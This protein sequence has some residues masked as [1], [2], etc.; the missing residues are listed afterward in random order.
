MG[1]KLIGHRGASSA[2]A[3][4]TIAAFTTAAELGADGIEF[5]VH[6]TAD[7]ELVVH[8]DYL[9]DRTTTGSG[10]MH[11]RPW[12][13][14]SSLD[15]GSWYSPDDQGQ[16]VPRLSEVLALSDLD[17]ELELKGLTL[18]FMRDVVAGVRSAGALDRTEFTSW[19]TP[20]L[21]SLKAENPDA[22]I[23]LFNRR[24]DPWMPYG[25]FE[26]YVASIAACGPFDVVHVYAGDISEATVAA[27][28]ARGMTAH[29]NDAM[30][31]SEVRQALA[32]GADRI[33][34][35]DVGLLVEL[36]GRTNV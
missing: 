14:V 9:L 4:N 11:Q 8:H 16:R 10:L 25:F 24:R 36:S 22:K 17:F 27:I 33:S 29:A 20:M 31:Q 23:A 26:E 12:T 28:H 5:D 2:H 19:N 15:A 35:N 18:G 21:I 6:A 32:A 1:P 7:G 30:S 34:S 3:E 13:Y